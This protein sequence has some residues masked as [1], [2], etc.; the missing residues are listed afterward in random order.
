M[1][2]FNVTIRTATATSG[3]ITAMGSS[4][5]AVHALVEAQVPTHIIA[6]ISVIEQ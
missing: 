1:R 3:T 6:T 2:K 4:A 5:S